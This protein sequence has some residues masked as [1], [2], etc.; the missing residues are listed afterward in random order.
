MTNNELYHHGILGQK[1]GVRRFQNKD[2]SLTPAGRKRADKLAKEYNKLVSGTKKN[3]ASSSNSPVKPKPKSISEM[4]D[5]ELQKVINRKRLEQQ[6]SQ[7]DPKK[8][9]AGKEFVDK[10]FKPAATNAGKDVLQA[11]LTKQGEKYLDVK[12][13]KK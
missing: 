1:W 4:S 7:L 3:Q 5:E 8:I 12:V 11:W 9:S 13:K 2:G 6:Y 10:V